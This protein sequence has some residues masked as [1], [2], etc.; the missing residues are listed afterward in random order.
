MDIYI[1]Y[2]II[3]I[4]EATFFLCYVK[5]LLYFYDFGLWLGNYKGYRIQKD[6]GIKRKPIDIFDIK[7]E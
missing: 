5:L 4:T 1:S 6:V 7:L 2:I 3:M